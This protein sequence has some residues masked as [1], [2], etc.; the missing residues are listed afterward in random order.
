MRQ[1]ISI[2][3]VAVC[4]ASFGLPVA[5]QQEQERDSLTGIGPV[6]VLIEELREDAERDGLT[7]DL[8]LTAG[9]LRRRLLVV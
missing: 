6:S 5:A 1:R 7:E 9:C 4:V 8:L 2:A 3:I